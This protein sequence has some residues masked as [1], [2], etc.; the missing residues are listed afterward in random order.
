MK[1]AGRSYL[2]GGMLVFLILM[3]VAGLA[4]GSLDIG[5]DGHS[6]FSICIP[7]DASVGTRAIAETLRRYLGAVSGADLPVVDSQT[8]SGK[9]IRLEVGSSADPDVN[10]S[11]YEDE[12]FRIKTVGDN[13]YLTAHTERG[14]QNAVYTF[15]ETYLGCRKY[16]STVEVIPHRPSITLPPIDDTQV[17]VVTFRL[18][19]LPDSAYSAWHK[20]SSLDDWGLFVHTFQTLVPPERYF[21]DYPEYFSENAGMRVADG[22]LCLTNPDVLN[23]VVPELRRRMAEM[24]SAR[25]W[26]VS[27]NDTYLPCTCPSCRAID[28][29]EG[30]PSGT[31]LTFVNRVA[32]EFPTKTISMLAYQYSRSAPK[33]IKPAPNVNIMLCTIECNRSKPIAQDS[34]STSFV[35]D[36]EDWSRLTHNIFLWDYVIQ[37]RNLV[38]PFPNLRVLQPN[39]QF[40]VRSGVTAIY[41]QGVG[42]KLGEF[43][44]LRNYLLCKLLWNP[45]VNF[46][47]VMTDF[48]QGYYGAAAPYVRQYIDAMHDALERSGEDLSIYGYPYP[49]ANGYLSDSMI[50]R[51]V[52]LFDQAEA[53]VAKQPELLS[54]VRTARLPLQFAQLE[55]AKM[56]GTGAR[57]FFARGADGTWHTRPELE[58]LLQTFVARCQQAGITMLE[59]HGTSPEEYQEATRRYLDRSMRRHLAL[60]RPVVMA[61]P[62]R[63]KYHNGEASALTDGLKGWN[64]YHMHWL[65]FEGAEMDA[66][67]DLGRVQSVS[68]IETDFLQDI[69]SWVFM[70]QAVEFLVSED[71]VVYRSVG[72][73]QDTVPPQ[74][75]GVVVAPFDAMFAPCRAKY[76]R[77]KTVSFKTC[78]AWHK[79]AGGPAWIFIDEIT[80]L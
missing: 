46:D 53:A 16:S 58:A 70:P 69:N 39:I 43:C 47:S 4:T 32:A 73:V 60:G 79:G 59:E 44:E 29:A 36:M 52:A 13:L 10:T 77:V 15:L 23:I 5:T 31:L 54:R 17:P 49:S 48:L 80:V 42:S 65:G 56:Y 51:Y 30:S 55:Q 3:P 27:Q 45:Y 2:A 66:T 11:L 14:I 28:S 33:H 21:K 63:T 1:R 12:G 22:Q 64:D 8:A 75:E 26:S 40:F 71:G 37:F 78:P 68:R 38:S 72:A 62:A 67:I 7:H 25:Y 24:P 50:A 9:T 34:T 61:V 19:D 74:R 20:L 76:V 35:K 6:D 57:G 18:L 41:E